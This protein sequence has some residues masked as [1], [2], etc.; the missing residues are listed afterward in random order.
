MLDFEGFFFLLQIVFEY[1]CLWLH[2]HGDQKMV[3]L[4]L[5]FPAVVSHLTQLLGTRFGSSA[6]T[7]KSI[8]Y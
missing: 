4:E 1:V 8:K 3:L 5:G 6:K 7:K 2:A